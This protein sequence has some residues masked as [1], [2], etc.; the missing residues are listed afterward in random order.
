MTKKEASDKLY[1]HAS[2]FY[3]CISQ[4]YE[5]K[6]KMFKALPHDAAGYLAYEE[7]LAFLDQMDLYRKELDD[8]AR[9][10]RGK[11]D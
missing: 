7:L 9:A 10:L 5:F 3:E 4:Q 1:E 6:L 2:C 8:I 11:N